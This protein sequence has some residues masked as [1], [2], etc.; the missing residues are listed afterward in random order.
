MLKE[1]FAR[2]EEHAPLSVMMRLALEHAMPAG[3]I[4]G[5]FEQTR[6]RQYP[7]ELLAAT[8]STHVS[9]ARVLMQGRAQGP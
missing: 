9:T 3:W 1:V 5:V 2:F 7:R 8:A 6:Q 4:D